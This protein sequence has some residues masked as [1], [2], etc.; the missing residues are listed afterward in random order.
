[1]KRIAA[2]YTELSRVER[3][4]LVALV[5]A[6]LVFLLVRMTLSWWVHPPDDA[7]QNKQLAAQ[8]TA[9]SASHHTQSEFATDNNPEAAPTA[10]FAFD[11]NTLD[12]AG[13]IQ[14]G[15][16]PKAIKGLL[17]WRAHGKHFYAKEDLKPLYN[18]PQ[19]EYERLAPYIAIAAAPRNNAPYYNHEFANN[20]YPP[21]PDKIDLNTADSALLDRGVRGIGAVLAH[22][23][24]ARRNALGGFLKPE[25]LLEV[26]HFPDSTFQQLKT[27]LVID[28]GEVRMMNLNTV[29]LEQLKAHPYIGEKTGQNI[30]LYRGLIKKFDNVEQLRQAPLMN[31]EIYRKIAPYFE[32]R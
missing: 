24:I 23:I 6:L 20:N 27:K 28:A 14:L 2:A 4:A 18:L 3:M 16:P 7:A 22:K 15:M 1:M 13:F 12:S 8:W 26:Y 25:Q 29:S 5:S 9:F 32:V 30:L 10:L 19:A 21:L 11:P 31:E 17:N